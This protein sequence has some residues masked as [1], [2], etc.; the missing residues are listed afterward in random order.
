MQKRVISNTPRQVTEYIFDGWF[1]RNNF[2]KLKSGWSRNSV[3]SDFSMFFEIQHCNFRND[4][5]SPIFKR[6]FDK[7]PPPSCQ[8]CK[9][10]PFLH[11][12]KISVEISTRLV[13]TCWPNF[14]HH[15]RA[16]NLLYK[17]LTL[18]F[19][20][21]SW[22]RRYLTFCAKVQY[23]GFSNNYLHIYL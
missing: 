12:L 2:L 1:T 3:V 14:S 17:T 21:L 5:G 18:K 23:S 19:S 13:N 10:S 11:Y 4:S 8:P 7:T 20:Y 16:L 6:H 22:L 15:Q 9:N